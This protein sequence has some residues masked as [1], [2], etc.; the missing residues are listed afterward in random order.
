MVM[1]TEVDTLLFDVLG[2]VVD[3]AGTVRAEL[4][5]ALDQT[6]IRRGQ[7]EALATAWGRRFASLVARIR[8]GA[9]WQS[10]DELYAEALADVLRDGPRLPG[11]T[12]QRL[13]VVGHRL[14]PW[15][16]A[17]VALQRLA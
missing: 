1:G 5:V 3:E 11:A 17:A 4:A 15:P 14:R 10:A 7:S 6:H 12:V 9:A 2:T 13:A 16:D 8:E